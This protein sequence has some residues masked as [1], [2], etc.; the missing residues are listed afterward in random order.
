M[1]PVARDARVAR[2]RPRRAAP[3]RRGVRA[4]PRP[5]VGR[6]GELDVLRAHWDRACTGEPGLVVVSGVSGI[7][8]SALVDRFADELR[9]DGALVLPVTCFEAERSLYLE[10][11]VQVVRAALRRVDPADVLALAGPASTRSPS[12]SPSW[13]T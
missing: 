6:D 12:S 5:L 7:G 11:L 4:R 3:G 8:R 2:H 10:P 9:R 1:R 13:P